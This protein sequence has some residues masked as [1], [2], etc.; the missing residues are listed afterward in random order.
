[1]LQFSYL[2]NVTITGNTSNGGGG[3]NH[4]GRS[5]GSFV[6][7]KNTIVV[8]NLTLGGQ[9]SD[10]VT[11]G[12]AGMISEGYNLVGFGTGCPAGGSG[13]L[14]T[15]TPAT[16]LNPTLANNG[17]PTFTH[18][19]P[20]G[21]PAINAGNPAV[22]GSG[23]DGACELLDQRGLVRPDRCDIGAYEF[24]GTAPNRPPTAT[25]DGYTTNEDSAL[26]V[27]A[28]GVLGN[29]SDSDPGDTITA[30]LV[31]GPSHAASFALNANGS[32][33]YTPAADYNGGDSFTYKARDSH[34]VD[35]ATV[36][37]SITVNAVNDPP[38]GTGG[39][40]FDGR[41]HGA[42]RRGAGWRSATTATPTRVTRS[43]PSS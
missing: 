29:D 4:D 8:G 34:G 2:N 42:R 3:I 37:A 17:G 22:P 39:R 15:T 28:P 11:S 26:T 7:F 31:A 19:L 1:M 14:T 6:R 23:T 27:A 36:T 9:P 25:G 21:S 43:M 38:T 5:S 13:D 32:F 20:A 41:G 40:L 10:C 35:S 18:A 16:A 12:G 33:N 24:G 30:V